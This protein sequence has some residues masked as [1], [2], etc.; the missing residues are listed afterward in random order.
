MFQNKLMLN[1]NYEIIYTWLWF[2]I[3]KER[4]VLTNNAK[5]KNV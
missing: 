4:K 1:L 2:K 3:S 5:Y